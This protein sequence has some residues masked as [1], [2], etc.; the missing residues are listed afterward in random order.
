LAISLPSLVERI[1]GS[2]LR[3]PKIIAL[4]TLCIITP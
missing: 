1:S 4:F 2:L 3:L